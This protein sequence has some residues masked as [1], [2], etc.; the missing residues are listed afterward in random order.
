MSLEEVT[1]EP[2][3]QVVRG[4]ILRAVYENIDTPVENAF[5]GEWP[6]HLS[7]MEAK[8]VVE[9]IKQTPPRRFV[10]FSQRR[11]ELALQEVQGTRVKEEDMNNHMNPRK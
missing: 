11:K 2:D 4:F 7:V 6:V 10:P 8:E 3:K 1:L 5:D 9:A